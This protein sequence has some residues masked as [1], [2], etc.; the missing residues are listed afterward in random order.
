VSAGQTNGSFTFRNNQRV[1][2]Y[3]SQA[4]F[5]RSAADPRPAVRLELAGAGLAD[6]WVTYVESGATPAF[7]SQLDASKLPNSTGLN[8]SSVAG[9]DNLAI[10]GRAAFTAATVLPLV[11]GVPAAGTFTLAATA[12]NNLPAGLDAYLRD[13]QTGQVTKLSVGTNYAFSVTATE[14]QTPLTGRFTLQFNAASPLAT[15]AAL[16]AAAVTLYPNP[17]RESFTVVVPAVAGASQVTAELRNALGQL[18]RQQAAGLPATGA[19]LTVPTAALA[20]GVYVLRLQAGSSTITQR[21][22]IQ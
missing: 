2:T 6:G 13:A 22:V 4:A 19:R 1:T 20:P 11:V 18:V 17:A 15:A 5:Q 9:A 14:A 7:D 10:D 21:V 3:A 16:T 12:L 8:L